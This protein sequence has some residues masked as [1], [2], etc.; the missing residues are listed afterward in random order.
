MTDMGFDDQLRLLEVTDT[1]A[2]EWMELAGYRMMNGEYE[3]A[4]ADLQ[5]AADLD[6]TNTL[7]K[8]NQALNTLFQGDTLG[9]RQQF[10]YL[11]PNQ[12]THEDRRV[13][14]PHRD[15]AASVV[16]LGAKESGAVVLVQLF[17]IGGRRRGQE[18]LAKRRFLLR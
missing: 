1:L 7:V 3:P 5:R 9:A 16:N 12:G 4:A 14:G 15:A 17:A 8:F 6:S 10:S 11:V 2:S 13:L 18:T